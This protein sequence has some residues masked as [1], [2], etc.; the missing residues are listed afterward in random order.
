LVKKT[1]SPTRA[2]FVPRRVAVKKRVNEIWVGRLDTSIA[3]LFRD[4][5]EVIG[6]FSSILIT[7]IDSSRDLRT[8]QSINKIV[9]EFTEH[10]FLDGGLVVT[11]TELLEMINVYS[12]FNGFDEIWLF[13]SPSVVTD[14]PH[15]PLHFCEY[16][17]IQS[18]IRLS[19]EPEQ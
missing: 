10:R 17:T 1:A 6:C 8:L 16:S 14:I 4:L 15:H 19:K 11:G 7:S 13:P 9:C 3:L 12:L 2:I 18:L 5:P